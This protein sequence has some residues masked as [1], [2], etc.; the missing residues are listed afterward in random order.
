VIQ[1]LAF[2]EATMLRLHHGRLCQPAG[3]HLDNF[4]KALLSYYH[5][6]L[7][8][9]AYTVSKAVLNNDK[10]KREIL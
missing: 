6:A 9:Q 8:D 4:Q 7:E 3:S 10:Q 2:F 1:G 5:I